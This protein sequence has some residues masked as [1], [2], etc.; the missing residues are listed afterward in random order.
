MTMI[1]KTTNCSR[2]APVRWLTSRWRLR[3]GGPSS[4][5]IGHCLVRWFAAQNMK[6]SLAD[7]VEVRS[8]F[9]FRI[10]ILGAYLPHPGSQGESQGWNRLI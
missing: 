9:L 8:G 2:L 10:L 4:D 5:S 3:A 1:D 6:S 7:A